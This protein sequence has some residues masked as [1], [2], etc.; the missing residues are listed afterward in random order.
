MK[1]IILFFTFFLLCFIALGQS[2][3]TNDEQEDNPILA[4]YIEYLGKERGTTAYLEMKKKAE[5]GNQEWNAKQAAKN[6]G[7]IYQ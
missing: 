7:E 6:N 3:E 1:A 2:E 4:K 5:I